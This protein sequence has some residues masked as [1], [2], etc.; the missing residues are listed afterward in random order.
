MNG[1]NAGQRYRDPSNGAQFGTGPRFGQDPRNGNALPYNSPPSATHGGF[2]PGAQMSRAEKFEDEKKRIIDSLFSKKDADGSSPESYI[3]HIRI[4]EDADYPSTPAPLDSPLHNKKPR[5]VL[6]A[7]KKSGR[8]RMHKGRENANGTFSIGKTWALDDL[9]RVESFTNAIPQTPEQQQNKQR[10]GAT[11]FLITIG[12]PYYWQ[13]ATAREKEFFIFSLIKIFRKYTGGKL[14]ELVGFSSQELDQLGGAATAQ[15]SPQVRNQPNGVPNTVTRVPSQDPPR[16]RAPRAE[17]HPPGSRIPSQDPP[18]PRAFPSD[19]ASPGSRIPSQDPPQPRAP[20]SDRKPLDTSRE[21]RD[22]PSQEREIQERPLHSTVHQE[23]RLLHSAASRERSLRTAGSHDRI[24]LPGSFPSTDS[25][26]S[27]ISQPQLKS[28]GS[29]SPSSR[30]TSAQPGSSRTPSESRNFTSNQYEQDPLSVQSAM[31]G[32]SSSEQSRQI[33]IHPSGSRFRAPSQQRSG[34]AD[35]RPRATVK[36]DGIPPALAIRD[37]RPTKPTIWNDNSSQS[38]RSN[39]AQTPLALSSE[40]MNADM[41]NESRQGRQLDG[42]YPVLNESQYTEKHSTSDVPLTKTPSEDALPERSIQHETTTAT[43]TSNIENSSIPPSSSPCLPTPPTETPPEPEVHRPGLGPMIKKKSNKEIALQF[44]KAATA[45]GAFMPRAGSAVDKMQDEKTSSGDG[46]TGVFQAPSLLRGVSQDDAKPAAS[47]AKADTRPSTPEVNKG[48]PSVSVTT[49]P[50]KLV[51]PV[52]EDKDKLQDANSQKPETSAAAVKPPIPPQDERRKQGRSDHSAKYA[53]SL[54]IAPSLLEGRTFEIDT[55]LN[56]FGWNEESD[57]T[58]YDDLEIGIRKELARV[59]AG[60]WL[61]A[62]E[63]NDDRTTVVRNMMDKVMAECEELDCLLTLY[64]VELG[65]LSEDVA[66]IEAQ[67][68]GLQ[69]QTANQKLLHTELKNLL[70]T[71]SISA[72]KLKVLKDASLTKTRGILEVESTISELYTAMLTIDPRLRH[73]D[74][75]PMSPDQ[76]TLHRSS[77]TGYAGTELSSMHAVRER[78]ESYRRESVDFIQRLKQYLSVKFRESEA[79]TLDA[80]NKH[81]DDKASSSTKL[82]DRLRESPKRGLWQYSPLILFAREME[83]TEW[84]DLMRMYEVCAKKPYQDEFKDNIFAWRRATRKPVGDEADVLF[85]AQEKESDSIVGRKLTVKRTKTVRADGSSRISSGDKPRDGKITAYEAFAG[86]LTEEARIIFIEQN[87]VVDLFHASSLDTTD[88]ADAI[89]IDPESRRGGD[90]LSKKPFDPDR[91]MARKVMGV[92]EEI[93][94]FWASEIQSL[95][96]WAVKQDALNSVG[97]L[98]ALESQLAELEETNQEYLAQVLGKFHDRLATQF[99]RFIEEQI[100]GIEDTKVK[101]KKRKGV[102]AFM[103]TFPNF[104]IALESMLPPTRSLDRLPIRG[105]VDEVYQ[106]INK[107]MFESLKFIAKE[108]PTTTTTTAQAHSLTGTGDPED[109]EALNHHIL[110]IENMNHYVEE[111]P[112]R[113]NPVLEDWNLRA[114]TEMNEHLDLYLSAVI[115]RPLGKLLDFVESTETLLLN[116]PGSPTA[117]ATRPSHS[118]SV[119]KKVL[120]SYDAK[121]IRRGIETLRKRVEKH[122]GDGDDTASLSKELVGKVLKACEERYLSVREMVGRLIRD[123]YE[124]TLEIE[125][126]RDDVLT[127]FKR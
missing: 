74:C 26:H 50:A 60:S 40:S 87:F 124:G 11:G 58:R 33:G 69:V 91:S 20:R 63:S 36:D 46:I 49:S 12:K 64:N 48:V 51:A 78:K 94:S 24:H 65:T 83:P 127:A 47:T 53:K 23:H 56:D 19:I 28:K 25:I 107:A 3:T 38:D 82:D 31:P 15:A 57:R 102:I 41:G 80:L 70:D 123:V 77:S 4:E 27:Q 5:V 17:I 89:A 113:S 32:R 101:I 75:R 104:S 18:P 112:I 2:P 98:F 110:L 30:A 44:R 81:R 95:A 117:V 116:N 106:S 6:V 126:R 85:T 88:F 39:H 121:E 45:Y 71:I 72:S 7:V 100:R 34:S 59:E 119:F 21:R 68:Q 1:S 111:V 8:V 118:R 84:E 29:A 120:A 22:R 103:K 122:F 105:I 55:V 109:K 67:S 99:T 54:G 86:A 76:A 42:D 52:T 61:G 92:I 37:P 66:Y 35:E 79:E 73:N 108:S 90:L 97:I 9:S 93:F 96:D 16:T 14:P 114:R 13:A 115:R 43:A 125:W 10:A 62:I